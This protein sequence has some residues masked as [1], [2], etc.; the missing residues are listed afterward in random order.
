MHRSMHSSDLH[1]I[2]FTVSHLTFFKRV[3]E[4]PE[5]VPTNKKGENN[6]LNRIVHT[7]YTLGLQKEF[8]NFISSGVKLLRTY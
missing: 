5:N 7:R 1:S 4:N 3:C 6:C 8:C 2:L